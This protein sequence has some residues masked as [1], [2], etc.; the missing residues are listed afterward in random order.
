MNEERELIEFEARAISPKPEI[1]VELKLD[2]LTLIGRIVVAEL[3]II[4]VL[5]LVLVLR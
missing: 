1:H 5:A 4:V 2:T 3:V